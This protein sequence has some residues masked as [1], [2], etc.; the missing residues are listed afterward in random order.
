[1]NF[2]SSIIVKLQ[3][4]TTVMEVYI[5]RVDQINLDN[6]C[7]HLEQSGVHVAHNY[8]TQNEAT[9]INF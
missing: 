8:Y 9:L 6:I 1:M 4:D 5:Y 7:D 2:Q 3:I